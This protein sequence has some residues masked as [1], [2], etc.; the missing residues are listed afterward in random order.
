[1]NALDCI[2][3]IC[4]NEHLVNANL[5][6]CLVS[7]TKVP[8][9][10]D[11]SRAK[12]N[13]VNDFV[14]L[15]DLAQA[16]NIVDYAGVGISIQASEISAID[17][18]SC[19]AEPFDVNTADDRAK[20]ILYRFGKLAY[21]EFSFSGKG[22]RVLFKHP[23]IDDYVKKYYIK[24]DKQ[25]IEFYQPNHSFRYVTLTGRTI[26]D[27][28]I[29]QHTSIL[30]TVYEF[31]DDYMLRP[32]I[33]R[34]RMEVIENDSRDLETLMKEV[35]KLK[36]KDMTFQNAWFALAPGSNSNESQLDFKLLSLIY[37]NITQDKE[38]IRLI[39]EQ[40]PYFKSKDYKHHQKWTYGNY[41]YYD[42]VYEHIRSK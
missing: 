41:R 27:N 33:N 5:R 26:S 16:N 10:I 28:P 34:P 11:G 35:K 18:D 29:E 42:Y 39:F 6:Y 1:M 12:P 37:E 3:Q 19:F 7:S 15:T 31:L 20:D 25:G 23:L 24:N 9:K 4:S 14:S 22:L 36:F 21:I 2:E 17:V 8:C 40:S 32:V 38:K 30:K 13:D